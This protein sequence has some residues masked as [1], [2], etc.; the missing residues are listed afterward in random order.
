MFGTVQDSVGILFSMLY[1]SKY[2]QDILLDWC[3][4]QELNLI[5]TTGG[6]GFAPRD[7]TP[8]VHAHTRPHKYQPETASPDLNTP[9]LRAVLSG[10]KFTKV[11]LS[12]CTNM[13]VH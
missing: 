6:T 5:L 8:E 11:L 10:F 13:K 7:V 3:D 1:V 2:V 12:T 4:E 9:S